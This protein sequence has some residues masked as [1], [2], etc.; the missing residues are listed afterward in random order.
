MYDV[1]NSDFSST[2]YETVFDHL[3]T[4]GPAAALTA[5]HWLNQTQCDVR[6]RGG[7]CC[8]LLIVS[9]MQHMG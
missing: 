6:E 1:N 5:L 2:I 8:N 7:A 3:P 9:E 4:Q